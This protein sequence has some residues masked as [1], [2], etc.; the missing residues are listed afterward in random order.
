[1][2]NRPEGGGSFSL[3]DN[4]YDYDIAAE[5]VLDSFCMIVTVIPLIQF[6]SSKLKLKVIDIY[7]HTSNST[8]TSRLNEF[9]HSEVTPSNLEWI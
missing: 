9:N 8:L 5:L 2:C 7:K 6:K 3:C 1:M 4:D